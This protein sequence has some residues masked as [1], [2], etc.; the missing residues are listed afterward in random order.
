MAKLELKSINKI[1]QGNVHAVKNLSLECE[2]GKFL[3]VLGPSGCGKSSTLRM[4]AGLEEITQGQMLIGGKDVTKMTSKERNVALAFESYALYPPMTIYENIAFPL[5]CA[6]VP[7]DEIR[8]RVMEVVEL[9]EI[10]SILDR[11]PAALSGGQMQAVGLA[12][13]LV[14]KPAV[15]LLDEPISHLDARQRGRM[16]V[17][18]KRMQMNMNITMIYVTHDQ[19]EA[20]AMADK[21][22][23]MNFGVLQQLGTPDEIYNH[24]S[25][26]FVAGF[27]GDPP[28]NMIELEVGEANGKVCLEEINCCIEMPIHVEE[29]IKRN[30][31]KPGSKVIF[32]IRPNYVFLHQKP[33]AMTMPGKIVIDEFL[34]EDRVFT[35]QIG[36]TARIQALVDSGIRLSEGS[37]IHVELQQDRIFLFDITTGEVL[38]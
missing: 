36:N 17:K 35:I 29:I 8:K 19:L 6:G 18:L 13:A 25:N 24:P 10:E 16:R 2:D 20:M 38:Q 33:R 5:E 32:G 9:V 26:T 3:A 30:N 22:A 31:V 34:G 27:I 1:Y 37:S 11:K 23:V 7:K 12:R 4:V 15:F 21:I 14:R 28:M